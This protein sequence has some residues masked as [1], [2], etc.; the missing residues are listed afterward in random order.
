MRR[1]TGHGD[2]IRPQYFVSVVFLLLGI[3]AFLW[4]LHEKD[5][6]VVFHIVATVGAGLVIVVFLRATVVA[7]CGLAWWRLL[8][9]LT[10]TPMRVA[11]G[12]RTISESINVLL[13]VAAVGGDVVRAMLLRSRRV[14]GGAAAAA[15]LID[16]LLQAASQALFMLVGVVMLLLLAGPSRLT[17]WAAA[18]VGAAALAVGSFYVAQRFGGA[19]M[20]ERGHASLLRRWQ[21]AGACIR[22]DEP[23]QT[24]Y[25]D[26]RAVGVSSALHALAWLML[27]LETWT[28][29]RLMGFPVSFAAALVVESLSQGLRSAAF[30]V[31]GGLGVQ[32]GGYMAFGAMFG[33]P[34]ET[35]LALSLVKR[36]PDLA[37][38]LPGLLAWYSLEVRRMLP[39][40]AVQHP[41]TSLEQTRTEYV[42]STQR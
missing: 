42:Y 8:R 7:T 32:E 15:T 18:G 16:V 17:L 24:I 31:P 40:R 9:R 39:V 14:T 37:I 1:S 33:I 20:L 22:L 28:A 34:P 35:A 38:G 6:R 41:A 11:I 13:P 10:A 27:T 5:Y 26:R 30:P 23:L 2:W 4:L 21:V 36:A 29:L 19:R 25:A 12:L 3:A